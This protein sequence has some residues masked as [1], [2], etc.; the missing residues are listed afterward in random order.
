MLLVLQPG[1]ST[2]DRPR[3]RKCYIQ[4]PGHQKGSPS[5]NRSP[6]TRRSCFPASRRSC[7]IRSAPCSWRRPSWREQ[8]PELDAKAALLDQSCYRL[9]RLAVNL[10]D[11]SLLPG[12]QSLPLKDTDVV[13]LVEELCLRAE[14]LAEELGLTLRFVSPLERH[15]CAVSPHHLEQLVYHLLSNAFKFT[16]AGGTV[17][18]EM[19]RGGGF[20]RLSVA[21]TGC[22]MAEDKLETLFDRY[23]HEGLM[24]PRPHGLGLG[25]PLC[26]RI[27][28]CHGG[29]ILAESRPG[30]GSR[31]TVS[32]PDR[33]ADS[34]DVSDVPL[35]YGGGFNKTLLALADAL[36][37]K[38]FLLRNE[39]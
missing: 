14:P 26:R 23:L 13:A 29:S 1:F 22:G 7:A 18:V 28:E 33:R 30:Q 15:I 16:P 37:A 21:D 4:C 19:R 5:W 12:G 31:F 35:E 24:D 27:A 17:T 8:D 9:L 25:L 34:G 20:L 38:A 2:V 32:L 39:D 10:T 3:A 36:P 6:K 11:A